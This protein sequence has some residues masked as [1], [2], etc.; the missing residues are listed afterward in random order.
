MIFEIAVDCACRESGI[1]ACAGSDNNSVQRHG[2]AHRMGFT[3]GT[4]S[5]IPCLFCLA[6]SLGPCELSVGPG[7]MNLT[8]PVGTVRVWPAAIAAGAVRTVAKTATVMGTRAHVRM[9]RSPCVSPR[10]VH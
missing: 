10:A 8:E 6:D 7:V 4:S 3:A 2:T 5:P 1:G 9:A